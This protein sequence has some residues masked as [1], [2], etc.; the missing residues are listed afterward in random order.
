MKII[1][2]LVL[3]V[4]L[5]DLPLFGGSTSF[6]VKQDSILARQRYH[7]RLAGSGNPAEKHWST[8][9]VYPT[10]VRLGNEIGLPI[11]FNENT[12]RISSGD[13]IL[14][15]GED[16]VFIPNA[17]RIRILDEDALTSQ[18]PLRITYERFTLGHKL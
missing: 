8:L 9:V 15:L 17:N 14:Q 5:I 3:L 1:T 2:A 18:H 12:V 16:Y 7:L 13:K 4:T 11:G 10:K 6:A